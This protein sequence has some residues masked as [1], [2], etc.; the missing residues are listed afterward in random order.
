MCAVLGIREREELIGHNDVDPV[1]IYSS[2]VSS[3]G[4]GG[5][6]ELYTMKA[7]VSSS[8]LSSLMYKSQSA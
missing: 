2:F 8:G 7:A 3:F 5:Y 4:G 6:I 1:H